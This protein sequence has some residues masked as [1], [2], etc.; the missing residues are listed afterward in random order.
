MDHTGQEQGTQS[1][2]ESIAIKSHRMIDAKT[3]IVTVEMGYI[4]M[5][6]F[7]INIIH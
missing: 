3:K 4:L 7:I 2:E 1:R 6:G 5:A